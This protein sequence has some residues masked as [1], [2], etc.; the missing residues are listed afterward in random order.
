MPEDA[1]LDGDEAVAVYANDSQVRHDLHKRKLGRGSFKQS[2][3]ERQVH[4]LPRG[5][6]P[7]ETRRTCSTEALGEK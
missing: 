3:P 2:L 4:R 1:I 7:R 6:A 5:G